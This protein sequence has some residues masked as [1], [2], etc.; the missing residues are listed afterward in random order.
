MSERERRL[1]S[2]RAVS[3]AASVWVLLVAGAV[4]LGWQL[5]IGILTSI[6]P[7]RVAMNPVTALGFAF[8]AAS[9]WLLQQ[10]APATSTR[11]RAVWIRRL[12]RTGAGLVVV[13]GIVTLAGY[14]IG[15]NLGVDQVLFR[16]RLGTNRIAPN[17]GVDFLLVGIA[18][19]LL[20]RRPR[21]DSR[22]VPSV[23]TVDRRPVDRVTDAQFVVLLP[24]GIALTSVLGYAYGVDA[25]YGFG[26]YIPMALPTA[27]GFLVLGVGVFCARPDRGFVAVIASDHAGG[28]LARRLLPAAIVIPAGLGWLRLLAQRSGIVSVELGQAIVA[29]GTMLV[30]ATLIAITSRSLDRADRRR[31]IGERRLAT[32]YAATRILVESGTLDEAMP[33][34]LETVG[35]SLGWVMGARWTVDASARVLRCAEIWVAPRWKLDAFVEASRRATFPRGV[36]LP[37][38]V[39]KDGTAAWISDVVTDENFPRAA[40]AATAGVHG[41]FAFPIASRSGCLGV[42]EFFSPEFRSPDEDVLEMF[43]ALGGQVGQFIERKQAE[44]E[45]ERAKAAAEAATQ[46]KSAFLANMSHEIRTPMNA[47]I[48]LSALMMDTRLDD[49][50]RDFAETIRASGDH[51]LTVINDILDF[52]R[53]ESGKLELE[54]RPF[55]PRECVKASIQL[56]APGVRHRSVALTAVVD[57]AVPAT[58]LG[59]AGRLRQV[60]VNLLGNALKFTPAGEIAVTVSAR[61]LAGTSHELHFAV[62]DTGIGI[63]PDRFDRLFESFSQVD[64]SMT[65]RYGGTGLGLAISRRLCQLMGGRIWAESEVGKGSTFHFTIVAEAISAPAHEERALPG[66]EPP[67]GLRI[68]VAEDNAINQKVAL[69]LLERLGHHADVVASG[70]EVLERLERTPYDVVLMDVQMPG[71]DGLEASRQVCARWPRQER[72]RIIA[73]TAAAMSDD[74]DRCLAAGM[75]EYVVKPVTL[76]ELRRV[77]A[78]CPPPS[79]SHVPEPVP[80]VSEEPRDDM[81]DRGVL[82]RLREDLGDADAL[83]EIIEDFLQRVPS[84]LTRLRDA[85]ARGDAAELVAAAHTLKGTS[86]T[87]GAFALAERCARLEELT[88]TGS[89]QDAAARVAVIETVYR[90][91]ERALRS[92]I[93]AS[94]A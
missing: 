20:D 90:V 32:Q 13:I 64:A 49:R 58:L 17:T 22:P 56:V 2:L 7:G 52:S 9:L 94:A 5:E 78:Q 47:I 26:R 30:F 62:R 63:P 88:R 37:G 85:A 53:I 69:R 54:A 15:A 55:D 29:A 39:W 48:G 44:A 16:A 66:S 10:P 77:L 40:A 42:M 4:L 18:L 43:A 25:L 76:D 8:A 65:R 68:L 93:A 41:A 46:A 60:L 73:M 12:A 50:Q 35:Q 92:E 67:C 38:R 81:P 23:D 72:P 74:R 57:P 19:L 83:R 21:Q 36:G 6:L 71:M 87:L 14:V 24:T 1:A 45:L 3:R 34:I 61:P 27:I 33:R 31:R 86:A 91:V 28:V 84:V 51:L 82:G 59:D 75:D 11:R 89:L 80:E 79:L 70:D